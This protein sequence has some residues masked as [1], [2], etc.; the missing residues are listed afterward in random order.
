MLSV[1]FIA[2]VRFQ[3]GCERLWLSQLLL[4]F[5]CMTLLNKVC[6]CV[7]L[8]RGSLWPEQGVKRWVGVYRAFLMVGWRYQIPEPEISDS[9]EITEGESSKEKKFK[10]LWLTFTKCFSFPLLNFFWLVPWHSDGDLPILPFANQSCPPVP[11]WSHY[12]PDPT[13]DTTNS[14]T[15][16]TTTSWARH[17]PW[18]R[19]GAV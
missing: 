15:E 3:Q 9:F 18:T 14:Q 5:F 4:L 16:N 1:K 8:H 10:G 7:C 12:S 6:L 13:I 19:A 2:F 11:S 17:Q